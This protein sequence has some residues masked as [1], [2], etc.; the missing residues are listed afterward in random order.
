MTVIVLQ[1][2]RES[3]RSYDALFQDSDKIIATA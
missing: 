3:L 1:R 2:D